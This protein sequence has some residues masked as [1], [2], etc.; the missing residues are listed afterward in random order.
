[1]DGATDFRLPVDELPERRW[2][3]TVVGQLAFVQVYR[4]PARNLE[5]RRPQYRGRKRDSEVRPECADLSDGIF[6]VQV[7]HTN[8]HDAREPENG[9]Y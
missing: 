4:A 5:E 3:S 8:M 7:R 9:P 6:A 2:H 1:M